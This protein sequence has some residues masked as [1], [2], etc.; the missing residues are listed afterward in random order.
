MKKLEKVEVVQSLRAVLGDSPAAVV[1]EYKGITVASLHTLRNQLRER[2][3][4]LRVVKNTLLLRAVDGTSNEALKDLAGGPIAVAYAAPDGEVA[5]LA[6]EIVAFKKQEDLL[7]I[8]GG[9]LSGK[10]LDVA[11]VQELATL[12]SLDELRAKT[13]GLFNAPAEKFL[14]TLLAA[15]RNFLGVLNA[16]VD[17]DESATN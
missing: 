16:K 15:P 3:A 11:G 5:G 8:R 14:S 10:T 6:K 9:V 2:G 12:P 7:V 4:T 13:L 1:V 17:N